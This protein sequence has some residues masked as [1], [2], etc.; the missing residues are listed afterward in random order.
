MGLCVVG[1]SGGSCGVVPDG[2]LKAGVEG[3]G[4]IGLEAVTDVPC[5]LRCYAQL[6][7]SVVEDARVRLAGVDICGCLLYT[8]PSPRD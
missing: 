4:D 6:L 7:Q 1:L 2:G 8:S 5:R 3:S